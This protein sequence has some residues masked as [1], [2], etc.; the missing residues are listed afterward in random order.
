MSDPDSGFS[1]TCD[2]VKWWQFWNPLGEKFLSQGSGCTGTFSDAGQGYLDAQDLLRQAGAANPDQIRA[3]VQALQDAMDKVAGLR[4]T[5]DLVDLVG[6]PT[7][8]DVSDLSP[9]RAAS[10]AYKANKIVL[11]ESND[12]SQAEY[13]DA[14]TKSVIALNMLKAGSQTMTFALE[15]LRK[16]FTVPEIVPGSL[17]TWIQ[18]GVFAVVAV[19][20]VVVGAKVYRAVKG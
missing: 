3:A 13:E 12:F 6:N 19:G 18:W 1:G 2:D 16:S 17:L 5:A 8:D 10:A 20:A 14:I 11:D 9:A 7:G 4:L 15:Q